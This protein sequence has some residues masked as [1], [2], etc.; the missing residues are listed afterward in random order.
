M[1][2]DV[3]AVEMSPIVVEARG[4]RADR[5]LAGFYDRRRLRGNTGVEPALD[6]EPE[7][8]NIPVFH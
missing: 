8:Q 2:L 7:Q 4:L 1:L 3:A 5:S 6:V